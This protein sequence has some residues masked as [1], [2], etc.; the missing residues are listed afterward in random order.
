MGLKSKVLFILFLLSMAIA[1]QHV[2]FKEGEILYETH[3][4]HCHMPKGEGV[5]D[6]YPALN[7]LTEDYAFEEIYCII[8]NGKNSPDRVVEMVA[9]N[10][11]SDVQLHNIVNYIKS[12]MNGLQ[13][14]FSA[15]ASREHLLPCPE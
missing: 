15:N 8:R 5:G 14:E 10:G 7:N 3:C 11:L 12:D 4:S 2:T 1:C 13:H 9:I 6:I